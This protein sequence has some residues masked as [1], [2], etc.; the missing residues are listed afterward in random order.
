MLRQPSGLFGGDQSG[1]STSRAQII[2]PEEMRDSEERDDMQARLDLMD[3]RGGLEEQ[4][5]RE[6]DQGVNEEM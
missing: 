6:L 1:P 5:E 4:I 3:V 2:E